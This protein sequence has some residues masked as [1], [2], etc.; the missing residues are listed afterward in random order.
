MTTTRLRE[1]TGRAWLPQYLLLAAIV[2]AYLNAIATPFQFDDW[3]VVHGNASVAGLA[4]WW[5][6]LP[7]IRPLLKLSYALNT[8]ASPDAWGFHAFNL[9]VHA[10]NV[11]LVLAL[12]RRWLGALAPTLP[13]GEFA[14]FA[15]ALLFALHP[16]CTE[17]VTY[18]SGRSVS[19][20]ALFALA[21]LLTL[22]AQTTDPG[23]R[24]RPWLSALLFALAVAVRETA[25]V[26]PL[27]WL[28]FAWCARI[29]AREALFALRGQALVLAMAIVAAAMTPGYRSFFAGSLDTRSLGE[30]LLGQVE[31]H[32]FLLSHTV[33]GLQTNI[34]PDLRVPEAWAA[35]VAAKAVA[36]VLLVSFALWQR[37]RRPWL[38][39]GLLWYFLQLLPTNSLLPRFDLANDRHV[40]LGLIGPAF[41]LGIALTRFRARAAATI[42]LAGLALL[43]GAATVWRNHDYRSELALWQATVRDSPAKARPRVN[44]GIARELAG[45]EEG[46]KR[47]YRCALALDPRN[48]QARNNLAVIF[49]GPVSPSGAD[50]VPP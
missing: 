30:Q 35:V 50:C 21:S 12:A 36:L 5:D 43:L 11:L 38:A 9:V 6:A 16:A 18:V 13:T 7:G 14:A 20:M 28:L 24:Q 4:A 15:T 3:W 17:A 44:L 29:P 40:Y 2:A 45:D 1:E 46:T 49:S 8:M 27:A 10:V 31:A 34:D 26:V 37:T 33:I 47:A 25:L 23:T 41:V 32:A 22:T 42:A 48:Q 19:L 39:F